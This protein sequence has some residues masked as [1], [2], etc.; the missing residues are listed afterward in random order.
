MVPLSFHSYSI[1]HAPVSP[2]PTHPLPSAGASIPSPSRRLP[3]L[4]QQ[5]EGADKARAQPPR[6]LARP[7]PPTPLFSPA[8]PACARP[9]APLAPPLAG[10]VGVAPP[11]FASPP[12]FSPSHHPSI[13]CRTGRSWIAG[14]RIHPRHLHFAVPGWKIQEQVVR[15]VLT[16]LVCLV[17]EEETT[18]NSAAPSRFR[19]SRAEG[20]PLTSAPEV[21]ECY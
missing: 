12:L 20:R 17:V 8:H 7:A 4:E 2:L 13:S 19:P 6:P 21:G 14:L 10:P 16:T 9:S 5:A 15:V 18:T 3:S 11:H 1:S